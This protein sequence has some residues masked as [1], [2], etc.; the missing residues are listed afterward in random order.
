[1]IRCRCGVQ[2]A[3]FMAHPVTVDNGSGFHH[4]LYLCAKCFVAWI[5]AEK[6]IQE[7]IDWIPTGADLK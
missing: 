1:M 5:G 3:Q 6:R 7:M 2:V 4:Y